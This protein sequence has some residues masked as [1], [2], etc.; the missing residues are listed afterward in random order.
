MSPHGLIGG[1]RSHAY[2]IRA[3]MHAQSPPMDSEKGC[4]LAAQRF[5]S[6]LLRGRRPCPP[7]EAAADVLLFQCPVVRLSVHQSD[8]SCR[9][10]TRVIGNSA[11]TNS[12][13]AGQQWPLRAPKASIYIRQVPEKPKEPRVSLIRLRVRILLDHTKNPALPLFFFSKEIQAPQTDRL[14][15]TTAY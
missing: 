10:H 11:A 12:Q 6:S 2:R 9:V 5:P 7:S 14:G 13:L 3:P 1:K 8:C 4:F 15:A